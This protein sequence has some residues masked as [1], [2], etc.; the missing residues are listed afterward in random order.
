MNRRVARTLGRAAIGPLV[1]LLAALAVAQPYPTPPPPAPP[2]P[3]TIAAPSEQRLANGLRVVVARRDNVPLVSAELVVLSGAEVDPPRLA[4]LASLGASLLTQGTQ[5]HSAPEIAAAAEAL[6]GSLGSGAGWNQSLVSI[7][8]TTPKLDAAL[9]LLSESVMEPAFAQEEID[10]LRAQ[11]LDGLKVAYANPG[12]LA[13]MAAEK[14]AYGSS[15]YGHPAGG[16]PAS[17]P[18]ITRADFL[19]WHDSNFRP[20][21]AVLILAGDVTPQAALALAQRHFGA[22]KAAAVAPPT[23][24]SAAPQAAAMP[25]VAVI[26]MAHSGQAAVVVASAL[27]VQGSGDWAV[28]SVVNAMLGGTTSSRLNQE[29]RIRRGLSYGAGSRISPRGQEALFLASVQ[30]K[31]ESAAEVVRLIDAEIDRFIAVPVE[32]AELDARR[33]TLIGGFSRSVETSAG[34]AN[35][36]RGLIVTGRSPAELT[37]RIQALQAVSPAD[38]QRYAA[39]RLGAANRRVVVAG[40][41]AAFGSALVAASPG[42]VTVPLAELDLEGVGGLSRR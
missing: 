22:W 10:R 1:W 27:P 24:V 38:V 16:T 25:R 5:H 30:T 37:T 13:S 40:E 19:T 9:A 14:L 11:E 7:T 36:I 18:R 26:D 17:L 42:A 4:G 34:L 15:P 12:T 31:N 3:L 32:A 28:G 39:T 6:G 29:I 23:P 41:A 21:N 2:R 35:A 8:V 20:G 33:E